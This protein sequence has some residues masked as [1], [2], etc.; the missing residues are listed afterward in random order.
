MFRICFLHRWA[1]T[2][3]TVSP[4]PPSPQSENLRRPVKIT[5]APNGA[6][7]MPM[8]HPALPITLSQIC[9]T[10][11]AC[12]TAGADALHLHIRDDAGLHTL[13]P[14]RYR[15]TLAALQ[16]TVPMLDV[17]ITTEAAGLF[18]VATQLNT[19]RSLRP[20][21]ASISVR[22]IM[23]TPPLAPEVYATAAE[24]NTLVQHILY[25]L[26][27]LKT[28]RGLLDRG[29]IPSQMRDILIVLGQ[30]TPARDATI[31]E[32]IPWQAALG[33]DFPNWTV[34]AF[35]P[36]E[37]AVA[38]AALAAGRDVRIGFENNLHR[39]DHTPARDNAENIARTVAAAKALGR[40]L[41]RE[42]PPS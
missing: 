35:G 6:R 39:P 1:P 34:C 38:C 41:L 31:A 2:M 15:D 26:N 24:A 37:H 32:L 27:D 25:D 3:S 16:D 28:L 14:E 29:T 40:P 36:Q 19:L 20:A 18:D 21:A 12:H 22:E 7:R 9:D 5:A 23:R 11:R 30:Y 17:Q 33:D 4:H 13:D 10:A 42:S 8:H